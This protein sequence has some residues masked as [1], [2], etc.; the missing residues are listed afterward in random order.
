[1]HSPDTRAGLA[2]IPPMTALRAF[3][4]AAQHCSFIRAA[5]AMNVT[6]AAVSQQVRLLEAHLGHQLFHRDRRHKLEPTDIAL[7]LLPGLVEG[8]ASITAA[9]HHLKKS[10]DDT[11]LRVSVAPSF[12]LKWLLP[13][14]HLLRDRHPEFDVRIATTTALADFSRDDTDCAI[15]FGA[16]SYPG[17]HSEV[18]LSDYVLPVCSP[19]LLKGRHPL[20]HI[21]QIRHHVLLHDDGAAIDASAPDWRSWL[22]SEGI[23]NLDASRGPRF[24]QALMVIEAAIAGQGIALARSNLISDDLATGRLV[25][26]F[27]EPRKVIH[28]YHFVCPPHKLVSSRIQRFL[29][30]LKDEAAKDRALSDDPTVASIDIRQQQAAFGRPD[31]RHHFAH[32]G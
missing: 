25:H 2:R 22:R 4:V 13:R 15:R 12:G 5:E 19:E 20:T 16:G 8:F 18:L 11:P 28:S 3:V 10:E 29:G 6:P 14:M 23:D 31:D 9:V 32:A 21:E 17:L 1:M 30:W 7:K 24:D 26:P 27:G